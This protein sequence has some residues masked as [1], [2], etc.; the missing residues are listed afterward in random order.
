MTREDFAT[1]IV[2]A[3]EAFG[4]EFEADDAVFA[5]D[6]EISGYAKDAIYKLKKAGIISGKGENNFAPKA[7]ATRAEAAKIIASVIG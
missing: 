7:T 4:Y 1:I 2:R 3:A 6:A 5:D